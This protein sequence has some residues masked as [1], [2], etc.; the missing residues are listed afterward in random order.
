MNNATA[1]EHAGVVALSLR[2]PIDQGRTA[3]I[4]ATRASRA[5]APPIPLS[6]VI[7]LALA[8]LMPGLIGHDPWKQDEAYVFGSIY[9]MLQTGDWIVPHVAGEPF[10]EKPPLF[11]L[12]AAALAKLISPLLPLHDA[13]RLASGMFVGLALIAVGW[14]ARRSWGDG[15]GRGAVLLMLSCLGLIVDAHMMLADLALTAGFAIALAGVVAC[16]KTLRWGGLLLG[17][18]AGMAFLAKGLIGPGVIGV[19]ALLL[20]IIFREWRSRA[21]LRQL[22]WAALA[23]LPWLTIWPAALYLRSP[24]LFQ[25]WFWDNNI[26]RFLGFSVLYLGA[27]NEPGFWWKTYPWFLFPAWLFAGLVFWTGRHAAWRLPAVQIGITFVTVM[28][29][30]LGIS[31]SAR[32]SY[33]QPMVPAIALIGAGAFREIPAWIER[34]LA[35]LGI[36][37]GGIAIIFSWLVWV[38]LVVAGQSPDWAWLGRLLPLDFK[39]PVSVTAVAAATVMTIGA[40]TFV[41]MTRKSQARGVACFC[42]S[43]TIVWGLAAT[44]WLP[45]IDSARSYRTMFQGMKVAVPSK[46]TCMASRGLGE[47]ERA[48]LHYVLDIKTHREEVEEVSRCDVLLVQSR[49]PHPRIRTD[50]VLVWSGHRPG[51]VRERF[52]LYIPSA[53]VASLE[54]HRRAPVVGSNAHSLNRSGFARDLRAD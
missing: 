14:S 25:I 37:L 49:A 19:T 26:G 12:V 51:D 43:L 53:S 7:A 9:H 38:F 5:I 24:E 16:Q 1:T 36:A 48:M 45:W 35:W 33:L 15:Y 54:L 3:V 21:Y 28:A 13:A 22:G 27:A 23:A 8:Y 40:V 29:V 30:V 10:L 34:A 50:K 42:T 31:A 41:L 4:A 17:T 46:T 18:G 52:A 20:P 44:L 32:A 47:S 2:E 11:H 6:L 39:L